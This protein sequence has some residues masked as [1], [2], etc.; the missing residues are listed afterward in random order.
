MTKLSTFVYPDEQTE[1]YCKARIHTIRQAG[2]VA[3]HTIKTM[4]DAF[5][6]VK[7]MLPHGMFGPWCETHW[8]YL[9][10]ASIN[11]YMN[12]AETV[13]KFPDA[14]K[15]ANN[16]DALYNLT[17]QVPDDVKESIIEQGPLSSDEVRRIVWEHRTRTMLQDSERNYAERCGDA[18]HEIEKAMND[19]VLRSAAVELLNERKD[20]FARLA[21]REPEEVE[22]EAGMTWDESCPPRKQLHDAAIPRLVKRNGRAVC[23][24]DRNGNW[25]P[26]AYIW[27]QFEV[28][29][30]TGYKVFLDLRHI[31]DGPLTSSLQRSAVDAVQQKTGAKTADELYGGVI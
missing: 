11:N 15:F 24:R 6:E 10:R 26:A 9:S 8:P 3:L 22:V 17:S 19:S 16:I 14:W 31:D 23:E 5:S 27:G 30:D 20:D 4:G 28:W 13:R 12:T 21:D 2:N 1:R 25:Q 7:A 29:Q 18:L